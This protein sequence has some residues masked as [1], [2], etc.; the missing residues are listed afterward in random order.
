MQPSLVAEPRELGVGRTCDIPFS[1]LE[2]S[3]KG[4]V[5]AAQSDDAGVDLEH[6][7]PR[8]ETPEEAQARVV[9]RRLALRWWK[10]RQICE[11]RAWLDAH[12]GEANA[13]GV[14]DCIQRIQEATYWSWPRGSRIFFWKIRDQPSWLVDFRDG[15]R[16]WKLAPP[17]R[18]HATNSPSPSRD[19]ELLARLK[20]FQL[21]YQR[22][23]Y[24]DDRPP[25]T[26]I[27]CFL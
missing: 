4:R 3:V 12:P 23:I 2:E 27:P 17:P 9:L 5:K 15:V 10:H 7:A 14:E 18:G 24:R 13:Q 11:A 1:P 16:Y 26:I 22:F 25:R 8:G 19:T 21:R 20:V 6:W